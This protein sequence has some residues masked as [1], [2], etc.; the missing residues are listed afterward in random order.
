MIAAL[1]IGAGIFNFIGGMMSKPWLTII[2]GLI[3]VCISVYKIIISFNGSFDHLI[4][5][6]FIPL[7]LG[8]HFVTY[9]NDK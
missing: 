6:H 9:G 3:V 4:V 5:T 2:C 1:A 8:L 7:A